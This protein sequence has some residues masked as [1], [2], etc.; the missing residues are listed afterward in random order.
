MSRKRVAGLV[1]AGGRSARFG[2]DKSMA[3]LRNRPLLDWAVSNLE[4]VVTKVAIS[5]AQHSAS[6]CYAREKRYL[7]LHDCV[8]TFLGPLAGILSGLEW[9]AGEDFDLILSL[10][11]DMPIVPE[12]VLKKLIGASAGCRLVHVCANGSVEPLC[13]VWPVAFGTRLRA[14]LDSGRHPAVR[15][16]QKLARARAVAYTGTDAFQNINST[17][18]LE[19]LEARLAERNTLSRQRGHQCRNR[20]FV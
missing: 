10:P 16:V 13:A 12:G 15:T 18:D 17:S 19:A 6:E 8:S 11:C 3:V 5:T 1:L 14:I 9:A 2:S 4:P 20:S 7:V